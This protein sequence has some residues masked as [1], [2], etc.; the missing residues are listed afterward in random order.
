MV[1]FVNNRSDSNNREEALALINQDPAGTS[2]ETL[3]TI[4][5]FCFEEVI[6]QARQELTVAV[7]KG[8]VT[9]RQVGEIVTELNNRYALQYVNE[10]SSSFE[11]EHLMWATIDEYVYRS[12]F[13]EEYRKA[14]ENVVN[15]N[16]SALTEEELITVV[17]AVNKNE[18]Q[19]MVS[20]MNKDLPN[21][22]ME[23]INRLGFNVPDWAYPQMIRE[24]VYKKAELQR[25]LT[26][27]EI[28]E[29]A[30]RVFSEL[31]LEFINNHPET[32]DIDVIAGL[33]HYSVEFVLIEQYREAIAQAKETIG[34]LTIGQV[35]KIIQNVRSNVLN[36]FVLK[37]NDNPSGFSYSELRSVVYWAKY[38]NLAE[39]RLAIE[40]KKSM[41]T[42]QLSA[43]DITIAVDSVHQSLA[44]AR[45]NADPE[46]LTES[47]L[48]EA[49]FMG[50]E[51]WLFPL[52]KQAIVK[53]WTETKKEF[54]VDQLRGI[55]AKIRRHAQTQA[56][57]DI[58]SN[59]SGF[60]MEMLG[61]AVFGAEKQLH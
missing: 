20:E 2:R 47:D 41:N 28:S 48:Y 27:Q 14:V 44:L 7:S 30:G 49:T 31:E 59:P 55:I 18:E 40:A 23:T 4:V 45:I 34:E 17:K 58:N 16:G 13:I 22:S 43:E 51:Y 38:E 33:S 12:D 24:L 19:R 52:Y 15:Q 56:L 29:V 46:N 61:M 60:T 25:D 8:K 50:N 35:E 42:S 1:E 11:L 53:E 10:H 57:A 36:D 54:T 5:G 26:F 3:N 9:T 32:F 21:V 37:I 39:Y 6:E